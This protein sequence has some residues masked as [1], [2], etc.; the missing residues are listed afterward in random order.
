M[1]S[2]DALRRNAGHD[3]HERGTGDRR[4]AIDAAGQL[5][6]RQDDGGRERG[7]GD[8][9]PD[10]GHERL[11]PLE[12]GDLAARLEIAVLVTPVVPGENP[13][14]D[15]GAQA[16][17]G[18]RHRKEGDDDHHPPHGDGR[19]VLLVTRL[20]MGSSMATVTKFSPIK[21]SAGKA[22]SQDPYAPSMS[23]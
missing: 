13:P 10:D 16:R 22:L 7:V 8:A 23:A 1:M 21:V 12:L 17:D 15:R 4:K 5:R 2:T 20:M 18:P 11:A 6:E 14:R 19:G 3:Q 9:R